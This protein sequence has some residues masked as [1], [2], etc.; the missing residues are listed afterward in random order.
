MV[1]PSR[2]RDLTTLDFQVFQQLPG[3]TSNKLYACTSGLCTDDGTSCVD[4]TTLRPH[5]PVPTTTTGYV[6]TPPDP[7]Y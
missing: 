2:V 4:G 7:A 6:F 5:C 1:D 3:L